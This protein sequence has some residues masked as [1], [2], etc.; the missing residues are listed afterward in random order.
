MPLSYSVLLLIQIS[1]GAISLLLWSAAFRQLN[2]HEPLLPRNPDRTA[3]LPPHL[4]LPLF[5]L[6]LLLLPELWMNWLKVPHDDHHANM[7]YRVLITP[8]VLLIA[9]GRKEWLSTL[10]NAIPPKALPSWQHVR[11]LLA[12][13]T[14]GFYLSLLP[15]FLMFLLV[16]PFRTEHRLINLLKEQGDLG[17]W[18]EVILSAVVIAPL[19]E[20]LMFRVLLQG[21]LAQIWKP[22]SAILF[23]AFIFGACHGPYDALPII[24][25]GIAL[26]YV[27]DRTGSYFAAVWTHALF[28]GFNLLMF[29]LRILSGGS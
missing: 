22:A 15:V 8:P 26:G 19:F 21:A 4:S 14:W 1:A 24:P 17:T 23:S 7:L 10:P 18:L 28:N 2:R 20:E 3:P 25:L 6:C 29:A 9:C 16:Q 5:L 13:G 12:A 27:Y 11:Q